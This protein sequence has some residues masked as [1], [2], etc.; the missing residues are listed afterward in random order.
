MNVVAVAPSVE[1]VSAFLA[2]LDDF[3]ANDPHTTEFYA[4]ARQD[5]AAYVGSL[6]DEEEGPAEDLKLASLVKHLKALLADGYHPIVFC[7]Y[8]QTAEYVAEQLEGKLGKPSLEVI[9]WVL[10]ELSKIGLEI[11]GFALALAWPRRAWLLLHPDGSRLIG[12]AAAPR[13]GDRCEVK[14][15][16]QTQVSRSIVMR[17]GVEARSAKAEGRSNRAGCG[18]SQTRRFLGFGGLLRGF[19][20]PSSP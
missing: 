4:P 13:A 6:I 5:F 1:Y 16:R 17:D 9:S 2:M 11:V 20:G 12:L 3:D 18:A 14:A 8:I 15:C 7:R 10:R 19:C